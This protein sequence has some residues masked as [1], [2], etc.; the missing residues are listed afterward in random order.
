[1]REGEISADATQV[2]ELCSELS[3][4]SKEMS[5]IFSKLSDFFRKISESST[6]ILGEIVGKSPKGLSIIGLLG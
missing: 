1:M 6:P 2:A 4:I 5:D 3:E